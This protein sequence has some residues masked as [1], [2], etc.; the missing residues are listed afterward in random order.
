MHN[1][2]PAKSFDDQILLYLKCAQ[3][4]DFSLKAAGFELIIL[5]NDKA[6]LQRIDKENYPIKIH[7]LDF[8]LQVPSGARFYASYFRLE[9]YTYLAQLTDDYLAL[10]DCDI[11]CINDMPPALKN[12]ITHKI[13]LYYDITDQMTP[14]YGAQRI[15]ED[16]EMLTK[17]KSVGL[18]SG[19]EFM[20]GPPSF[21]KRLYEEINLI[22]S[23]YFERINEFA[24]QGDEMII[25]SAI[26]KI[27]LS[28]DAR[29]MD[30]GKLSIIGRCWSPKPK[31]AQVSLK[32]FTNYFLLHLP[33]DKKFI[34]NLDTSKLR[35]KR[36]F[37]QYKYH[38]A[39]YRFLHT[40]YYKIKPFV[41][42]KKKAS[43]TS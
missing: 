34:A 39:K 10:I 40:A 19:G 36:F 32:G 28:D 7:Q 22:K 29:L 20:A 5:T 33:S 38:F 24:V 18:W 30:A 17:R 43:H 27:L 16:K 31:H 21:F 25:S 35:G 15:I 41:K 9:L 13:P 23:D 12:C 26:E 6:F 2:T 42:G 3:Q 11:L 4:L 14:A 37:D 1:G 8:H